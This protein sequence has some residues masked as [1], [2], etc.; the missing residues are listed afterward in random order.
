MAASA[1]LVH[2]WSGAI[3]AHFMFFVMVALLSVYQDWVP[4]LVALAFVV[5]HHGA[6]GVLHPAAVYDHADAVEHPWTWAL[7]HGAF[8]LAAAAANTYGWLSSEQDH[9]RMAAEI[10]RSE[11]TFRALFERNPQPLWVFDTESLEILAV[12]GA[13]ARHYCC[14]RD[15]FTGLRLTDVVDA[16]DVPRLLGVNG[17]DRHEEADSVSTH[18][19]R[20]GRSLPVICHAEHLVFDGRQARLVVVFDLSERISLEEELR[21]RAFHDSLTSLGNRELFIDRLEHALA[22]SR[23]STSLAVITIDLDGFKAVNDAHGHVG[24]DRVLVEVASRIL[25]ATRPGDTTARMGG[26]EFS[27]L[28][29]AT[30]VAS[31]QRV[32]DRILRAI[33]RPIVVDDAEIR[34]AAS[35]GVAMRQTGTA[36]AADILK[37]ADVAM[38]EAKAGGRCRIEVFKEG[39]R[40]RVLRRVELAGELRGAAERGELVLEYQPIIDI[41]TGAVRSVEGLVRWKHPVRGLMQ[42]LEFIPIAEETGVIVEVGAWALREACTQLVAWRS[43]IAFDRPLTVSVNISPR[44]LREPDFVASVV[45]VLQS[46]GVSPSDLTLEVTEGTVVEDVA[47]ASGSLAR[48]RALGVRISID[49]FGTGYSSIGYLN[50]LPLDEIKIDRMFVKG[51]TGK[52]EGRELVLAVV[53]LVDTLDVTT[54]VE[55]VETEEELDYVTALG[56]DCAQGFYFSRPVS[57]QVMAG[58]LASP[59][60]SAASGSAP[61]DRVA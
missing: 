5:V 61:T 13:A 34:I 44:Q 48:L 3:E 24:G 12:N 43:A 7:I 15:E 21:H 36:L 40:S 20:D 60:F 56:V 14:S 57:A 25:Q 2:L 52:G 1:L 55:G 46:S 10:R 53:R 39:M 33:R 22:R 26:D 37:Q 11:E 51:L 17:G 23:E 29:E 58:L 35:V 28:L 19:A 49:D 27:V 41:A 59:R 4:F 54:V 8:V 6:V 30:G 31:A 18:H 45:T 50:S 9:H 42:P 32:G 16:T 38:Y 47:Q